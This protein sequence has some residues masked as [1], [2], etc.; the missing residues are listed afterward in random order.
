M[1]RQVDEIELEE[2]L[3][4]E[5]ELQN[6]EEM[7]YERFPSDCSK[8]CLCKHNTGEA[9][10]VRKGKGKGGAIRMHHERSL[11]N[12]LAEFLFGALCTIQSSPTRIISA[13]QF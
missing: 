1:E 11:G 9:G 13:C 3:G 7:G 10:G 12:F 4:E 8:T 5:K 6:A 2:V